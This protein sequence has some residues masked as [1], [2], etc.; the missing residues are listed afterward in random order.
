[1]TARRLVQVA[2]GGAAR[3]RMTLHA[4]WSFAHAVLSTWAWERR[5]RIARIASR[6]PEMRD[7]QQAVLDSRGTD[8]GVVAGAGLA[9]DDLQAGQQGPGGQLTAALVPWS[10]DAGRLPPLAIHSSP[11]TPAGPQS[12]CLSPLPPSHPTA[13]F[14]T[15]EKSSKLA[16]T[17]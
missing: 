15:L 14:L 2:G 6:L 11:N 9:G 3:G 10:A 12:V 8:A 7:L 16:G 1:M 17:M 4:G 13:P 5:A